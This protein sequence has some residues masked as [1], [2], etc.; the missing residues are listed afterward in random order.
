MTPT[1]R[2][3]KVYNALKTLT[4]PGKKQETQLNDSLKRR[5]RASGCRQQLERAETVDDGGG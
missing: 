2:G 1:E 3:S 5:D 4:W